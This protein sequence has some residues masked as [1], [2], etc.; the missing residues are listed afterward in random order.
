MDRYM[1]KLRDQVFHSGG[2]VNVHVRAVSM[3]GLPSRSPNMG[4]TCSLYGELSC[5]PLM[6]REVA[7][8]GTSWLFSSPPEEGS[9]FTISQL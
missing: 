3:N 1:G 5:S 2:Q 4:V 6:V 8:A 7:V 9:S